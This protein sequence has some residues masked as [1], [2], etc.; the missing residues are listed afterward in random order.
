MTGLS[1]TYDDSFGPT[2]IDTDASSHSFNSFYGGVGG[3]PLFTRLL[4][5]PLMDY[6]PGL[7]LGVVALA[8]LATTGFFSGSRG[9]AEISQDA[10]PLM[11][12]RTSGASLSD[13]GTAK[14]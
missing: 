1:I 13:Y 4:S 14:V 5:L 7:G 11:N 9:R 8:A 6:V 12:D 3:K 10:L 2:Y